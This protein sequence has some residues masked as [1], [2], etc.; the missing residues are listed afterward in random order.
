MDE[1]ERIENNCLKFSHISH[2]LCS[3]M[4]ALFN[5]YES[6]IKGSLGE[7]R[8]VAIIYSYELPITVDLE[9][10]VELCRH[11]A[12]YHPAA[13]RGIILS[14]IQIYLIDLFVKNL[15]TKNSAYKFEWLG[16]TK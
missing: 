13:F 6:S 5:F 3:R 2:S 7:N 11:P 4:S 16:N 10:H 9:K 14:S 15:V 8:E 1:L 12:E